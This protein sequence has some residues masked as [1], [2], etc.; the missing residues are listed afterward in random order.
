MAPDALIRSLAACCPARSEVGAA[1][2]PAFG[3]APKYWSAHQAVA[4]M[5]EDSGELRRLAAALAAVFHIEKRRGD[6]LARLAELKVAAEAPVYELAFACL[7]DLDI[8]V[9]L[10]DMLQ[11]LEGGAPADEALRACGRQL[12]TY[13][14]R[15]TEPPPDPRPAP[16]G[17]FAP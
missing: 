8:V 12:A 17:H 5:A 7:D 10:A 11:G 4:R 13:H 16:A 9:P 1:I 2:A 6:V 15:L 14:R 3:V